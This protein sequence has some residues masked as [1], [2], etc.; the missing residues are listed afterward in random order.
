MN[1]MYRPSRALVLM[2]L[3]AL[4]ALG[5]AVAQTDP[6]PAADPLNT[7]QCRAARTRLDVATT[8]AVGRHEASQRALKAA[9][10]RV[11]RVCFGQPADNTA[12]A[13][14]GRAVHRP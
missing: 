10:E 14:Q 7:P 6:A 2:A 12:A 8:A 3:T 5:S 9:R 11:A 13:V 1:R 4:T